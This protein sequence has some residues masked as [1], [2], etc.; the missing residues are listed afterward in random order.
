[1]A[2][3]DWP[4]WMPE[5]PDEICFGAQFPDFQ[6]SLLAWYDE[7]KRRD[8]DFGHVTPPRKPLPLGT[9]I[10]AA[11]RAAFPLPED[12]TPTEA[13]LRGIEQAWRGEGTYLTEEELDDGA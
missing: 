11:K 5:P 1:M 13:T 10:E 3:A 12:E 2:A 4:A 8:P 7:A 6:K 9:D